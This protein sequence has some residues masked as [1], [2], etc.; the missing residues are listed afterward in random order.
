MIRT[1]ELKRIIAKNGLSQSN[2]TS[3]IGITLKTF[4]KKM[5]NGAF[6]S[7]ELHIEDPMAFFLLASN[8]LSCNGREC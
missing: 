7:D 4:Y 3:V 8:L 1:D 5:K 6:G 2:V